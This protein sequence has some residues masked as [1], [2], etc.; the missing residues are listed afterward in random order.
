ME[1]YIRKGTKNLRVEAA[2]VGV[3]DIDAIANWCGAQIVEEKDALTGQASEALNV[4]TPTGRKRASAGFY[5]IKHGDTTQVLSAGEF[6]SHFRPVET[7]QA[8][9]P[10]KPRHPVTNDPFEGM[11]RFN[12]GPKP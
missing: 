3:D 8:P 1:S 12:E 9:V 7:P 11:T 10:A 6:R 5:V 2:Q 4:K